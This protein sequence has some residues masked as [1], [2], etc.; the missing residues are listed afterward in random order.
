MLMTL[1]LQVTEVALSG[2]L[3]ISSSGPG[4]LPKV[5]ILHMVVARGTQTIRNGKLNQAFIFVGVVACLSDH[6]LS[7]SRL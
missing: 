1:M 2:L 3:P 4:A 6:A 5:V 7:S